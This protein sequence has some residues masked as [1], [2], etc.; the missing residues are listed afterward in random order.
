MKDLE[1]FTEIFESLGYGY[2]QSL[3][4]ESYEIVQIILPFV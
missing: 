1:S 2:G 4:C 3:N